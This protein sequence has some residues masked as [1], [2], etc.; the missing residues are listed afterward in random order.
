MF[1]LRSSV[2]CRSKVS[3]LPS[4]SSTHC[5]VCLAKKFNTQIPLGAQFCFKHLKLETKEEKN[6]TICSPNTQATVP[7]ESTPSNEMLVSEDI[8]I[9]EDDVL[10]TAS[11]S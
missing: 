4:S 11:M 1:S 8:S 5:F 6:K 9:S 10:D 3:S 2:F 7:K